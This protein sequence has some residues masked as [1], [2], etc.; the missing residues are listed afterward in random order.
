MAQHHWP[1]S[2]H[3]LLI[4]LF[5]SSPG[6]VAGAMAVH[7][8]P[9]SARELRQPKTSLSWLPIMLWRCLFTVF[10]QFSAMANLRVSGIFESIEGDLGSISCVSGPR[11]VAFSSFPGLDLNG[12]TAERPK[13]LRA[14]SWACHR[15][16][17]QRTQA[18]GLRGLCGLGNAEE[19]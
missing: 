19:I 13:K 7:E 14:S 17:S 10:G 16:A 8:R 18:L 9:I 1:V 5:I 4:R 11:L 15:L 6:L 3:W 12:C 2:P